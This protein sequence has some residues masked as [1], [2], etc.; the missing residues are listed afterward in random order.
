MTGL[1]KLLMWKASGGAGP[2]APLVEATASGNPATFTTDVIRPLVACTISFTPVQDGSGDPSPEN[3]RPISGWDG[4]SVF[5]SA[6]DTGGTEYPVSWTGTVY[7]GAVDTVNG[8][9]TKSHGSFWGTDISDIRVDRY[10]DST[11]IGRLGIDTIPSLSSTGII[12]N[13]F[14]TNISSGN[15]GR[16]VL[17]ISTHVLYIVMPRSDFDGTPTGDSVRQW[18][19]D[20]PT[21]FVYPLTTP[22]TDQAS[23]SSIRTLIGDNNVRSDANGTIELTYLKKE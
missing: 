23:R 2:V 8:T 11:V 19:T 4:V 12:S 17:V 6:T 5:V 10:D 14:S 16:M 13:R 1:K 18:L 15:A 21:L 9:L 7:G 20:H 22:V 3:V